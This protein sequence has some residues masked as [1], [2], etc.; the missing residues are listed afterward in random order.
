LTLRT[1]DTDGSPDD[2]RAESQSSY[3][4]QTGGDKGR[5]LIRPAAI[6]SAAIE[7][8]AIESAAIESAVIAQDRIHSASPIDR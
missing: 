3:R 2:G 6:E 1:L 7:S 8:A 5:R 4:H